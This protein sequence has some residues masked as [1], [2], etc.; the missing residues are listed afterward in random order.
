VVLFSGLIGFITYFGSIERQLYPYIHD[1]ENGYIK[2]EEINFHINYD[3]VDP[4]ALFE[5]IPQ[6]KYL[7]IDNIEDQM[8]EYEA[9][10]KRGLDDEAASI[11]ED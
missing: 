10:A 6:P 4:F 9:D 3:V 11:I 7:Q 2:P 8:P 5:N 1:A